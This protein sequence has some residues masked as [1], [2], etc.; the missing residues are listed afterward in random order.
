MR[1]ITL[2]DFLKSVNHKIN[3]SAEYLWNCYGKNVF[4]L[5]ADKERKKEFVLSAEVIF[6]TKNSKVYQMESWDYKKRIIYRWIDP[7]YIKKY[8]KES[9]QRGIESNTLEIAGE[10]FNIIYVSATKILRE[11]KIAMNQ[12]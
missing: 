9:K 12:P 7:S 8:L 6:D 2:K 1:Y 4:C 10:H 11:T 5:A 3:D